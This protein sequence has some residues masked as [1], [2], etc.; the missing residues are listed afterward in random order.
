[1]FLTALIV[2]EFEIL[3]EWARQ[4]SITITDN[5]DLVITP[6]VRKHYQSVIDAIQKDLPNYER[7]RRFELLPAVLTVENGEITPSLKVRRKVVEQKFADL[8][9]RMYEKVA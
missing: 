9:E 1:M 6:E 3:R 8:I 7:V 5:A 2:P 4:Q